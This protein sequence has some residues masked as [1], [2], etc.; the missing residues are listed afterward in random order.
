MPGMDGLLFLENLRAIRRETF[1]VLTTGGADPV[2]G[3]RALAAGAFDFLPKP[4]DGKELAASLQLAILGATIARTI[5][6]LQRRLA[7]LQT[8]Q[9]DVVQS[10][11]DCVHVTPGLSQLEVI[12]NPAID[13][14]ALAASK[15]LHGRLERRRMELQGTLRAIEN[16]AR[17]RALARIRAA[18]LSQRRMTAPPPDSR[19][20]HHGG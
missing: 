17:D 11:P 3:T 10:S 6:A 12:R 1:V 19:T 9:G 14:Q 8:K 7:R 5:T 13:D 18:C 20:S 15:E 2:L 16:D 4:F